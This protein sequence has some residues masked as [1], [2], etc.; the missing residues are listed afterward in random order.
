MNKIH[1]GEIE[2]A[3]F[4]EGEASADVAE[5][6][7]W[8]AR[9]RSG[10]A[11]YRWLQGEVAATLALAADRV[12]LPR[13][14]WWAV[15]ESLA[16]G[17]RRRVVRQRASVLASL[18]LAFL[19]ILSAPGLLGTTIVAQAV[20]ADVQ[21]APVP[22]ALSRVGATSTVDV[23]AGP[24]ATPTPAI[25]WGDGASPAPAVPLLPPPTRPTPSLNGI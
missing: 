18:A 13:P 4:E 6:L 25:L 10:V 21:V 9:C 23:G 20:P 8:C 16:T 5:H 15:C 2:L 7:H 19:L 24:L 22:V 1:P 3:R 14:R 11:D 17:Q 12:P